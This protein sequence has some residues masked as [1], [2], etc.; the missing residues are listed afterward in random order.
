MDKLSVNEKVDKIVAYI[1]FLGFDFSEDTRCNANDHI[2]ATLADAILQ[3]GLNYRTVVK[4]R[5]ERILCT[6][7]AYTTVTQVI[8][9]INEIGANEFLNW[10]NTE[11]IKRFIKLL[12]MC[13]RHNI[14]Y[15]TDL[16]NWIIDHKNQ[17]ELLSIR[18]IGPKT[19]DY[20]KLLLGLSSIPID[21]HLLKFASLCEVKLTK[22]AEASTVYKLACE[23]L[24]VEYEALDYTIWNLMS[25]I[26]FS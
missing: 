3:S 14:E 9:L 15:E 7:P 1:T 19:V 21:R 22:Y 5:I 20:L 17:E 18:G 12:N 2:G 23:K 24:N 16:K 6:Y 10:N 13:K 25:S 4:P 26:A 8:N 11:K